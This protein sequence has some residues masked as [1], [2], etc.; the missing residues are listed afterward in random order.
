M[1]EISKLR[2]ILRAYAGERTVTETQHLDRLKECE[3]CEFNSNNIEKNILQTLREGIQGD[4]C[5]ACGCS[6]LEKTSQASESCAAPLRG[7]VSRWEKL[8][9]ET[10]SK[11]DID[12]MNLSKGVVKNMQIVNREIVLYVGEVSRNEEL[13]VEV[14]IPSEYALVTVSSGCGDCSKVS[15]KKT[16]EY[17]HITY[18]YHDTKLLGVF[19]KKFTVYHNIPTRK[20]GMQ[21]IRI[22]PNIVRVTG[23]IV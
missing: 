17:A 15:L 6:V 19:S 2:S 14:G 10:T 9:I 20:G 11:T 7:K 12:V 5:V 21:K 13:V 22:V 16:P 1:R 8:L 4:Y 18:T 3:G 23:K